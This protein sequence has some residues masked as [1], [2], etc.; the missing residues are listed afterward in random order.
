MNTIALKLLMGVGIT[1]TTTISLAADIPDSGRMLREST[2]PAMAAP[3]R[4]QPVILVPSEPVRATPGD[5]IKFLV[6][7][8]VFNGNKAFSTQELN[9]LMA[10]VF[11]KELNLRELEQ[12]VAN[13]THAYVS[14]GH[15][16]ATAIIPPQTIKPN[17]PIRV[18][19]LEGVL[20]GI[21]LK[22]SPSE[23]RVPRYLLERYRNRI[24]AGKPAE[25]INL[26]E[27]SMLINELPALQSRIVLEP[28]KELGGTKGTLEVTE[29]KPYRIQF[30][31]DNYGAYSTGYYRVNSSLELFSPFRLGDRLT[32]RG[33]SSTSGD[34]QNAGVNWSVPVASYG[35]TIALD[36]SWVRYELG[37]SFSSLNANGDAHG[38]NLMFTQPL[39]RRS[40]L[41]LNSFLAGDGKLLD[42][43]IGTPDNTVNMK[44]RHLISGQAGLILSAEDTLLGGGSST[45]SVSYDGGMVGF[46]DDAAKLLDQGVSGLQ[47]QGNFSKI[48]GGGVA[49]SGHLRG[50]FPLCPAHRPVEQSEPGQL[51]TDLPGWG[52]RRT[53]LSGG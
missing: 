24:E 18:D 49:R 6:T 33:Q 51:G 45:F 25:E 30:G 11:G 52:I 21:E 53:G 23:T 5:S 31:A 28:G 32:L 3:H 50:S 48:S 44:R 37:R 36:Y 22:T 27:T 14:K 12:A 13:I 29:G 43:R 19:I 17:Q 10:P 15:F 46:D 8:F 26:I 2:P 41:V 1:L 9:R 20:E 40:Y 4:E 34:T 16:L 47:T 42:D 38:F 39:V 7:S 35:A